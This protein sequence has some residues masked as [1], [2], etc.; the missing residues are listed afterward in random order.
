M[1]RRP[2]PLHFDPFKV[3][4]LQ[5]GRFRIALSILLAIF[6]IG[7]IGYMVIEDWSFMDSLFMT[8]ITIT[9][10]GY[11]EVHPLS[12]GGRIFSMVLMIGGIGTMFYT[13]T[14]II[15]YVAEGQFGSRLWR[16][17]MKDRIDDLKNHFIICGYGR[18]GRE[19]TEHLRTQGYPFV[20][21]EKEQAGFDRAAREGCLCI[22]ADVTSD[23]T[24]KEAGIE[25]A[26]ALIAAVGQDVDN[27][28]VTLSA[29]ELN[30]NIFIAARASSE[31]SER[32]L[33]RAGANRI[34]FPE[35]LGGHRLAMTALRPWVVDFIDATLYGRQKEFALEDI[36]I[37]PQSP[38]SG[39]TIAEGQGTC[40]GAT[41]LAIKKKD[42]TLIPHPSLITVIEAGDEVVVIGTIEQ[43]RALEGSN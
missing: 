12:G 31:D 30:P 18:V 19:V 5:M 6:V 20:V 4:L 40:G 15:Q 43:L 28:Y 38:V 37:G 13:A 17:R 21:I 16:R 33:R 2:I 9:T 1:K 25:R 24:L 10:T 26:K 7:I 32:K 27:V 3:N 8:V 22:L 29:R 14:I 42:G 35:R 41:I 11:G 36:A 23:Q 34:V 39:K